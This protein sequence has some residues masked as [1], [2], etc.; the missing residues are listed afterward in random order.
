[1]PAHETGWSILGRAIPGKG[2]VEDASGPEAARRFAR[3]LNILLK[4]V[5]L[6]G[7]EHERTTTLLGTAWEDLRA[8]LAAAGKTE[9]RFGPACC[10]ATSGS[11][12]RFAVL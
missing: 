11:G 6:Y 7:A 2:N 3:S 8:A 12:F 9:K 4:T 10:I 1:M 5:R